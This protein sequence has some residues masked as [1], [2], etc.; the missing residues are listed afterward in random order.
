MERDLLIE[1]EK[2]KAIKVITEYNIQYKTDEYKKLVV[3]YDYLNKI[4]E[5][6]TDNNKKKRLL[7]DITTIKLYL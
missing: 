2:R 7:E 3:T 5:T 1:E 4:Y 6:E